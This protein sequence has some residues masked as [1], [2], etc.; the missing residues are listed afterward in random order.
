MK[1][2][3]MLCGDVLYVNAQSSH[4]RDDH[5]LSTNNSNINSRL[6]GGRNIQVFPKSSFFAIEDDNFKLFTTGLRQRSTNGS[7]IIAYHIL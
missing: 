3:E 4:Y 5:H 6:K 7:S 1:S 2:S